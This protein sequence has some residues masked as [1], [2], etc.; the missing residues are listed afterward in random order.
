MKNKKKLETSKKILYISYVVAI[1][2]TIIVII[3]TF[4]GLECSNITTIAG[5]AWLEVSASNVFY[6]NM[7]KKLNTPKIV[8]GIYE[9]LP[10]ELKEQV[11]EN[12]LLMS[13]MN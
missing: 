12:S 11:D 4:A 9:G 2:L 5:S 3:C 1:A 6:Y 13:L 7:N 10:E 8:Y